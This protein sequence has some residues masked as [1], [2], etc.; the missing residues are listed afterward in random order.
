MFRINERRTKPA[1]EAVLAK[2]ANLN[3][4]AKKQKSYEELTTRDL[5][6]IVEAMCP[7]LNLFNREYP[8]FLPHAVRAIIE[9]PNLA[10]SDRM[11][12][13]SY[14]KIFKLDWRGDVH[15][16]NKD[17]F[18]STNPVY[19]DHRDQSSTKPMLNMNYE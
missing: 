1:R 9:H 6:L 15:I 4:S 14:S 10:R 11:T 2:I 3:D 12:M 8:V 16:M 17:E 7:R 13:D 19:L 18:M 5:H